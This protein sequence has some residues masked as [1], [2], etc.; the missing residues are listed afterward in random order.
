[1]CQ[2]SDMVVR[3]AA[4][5]AA[6]L[7]LG[8]TVQPVFAHAD[9]EQAK[10]MGGL[11]ALYPSDVDAHA[12]AVPGGTPPEELHLTLVNYGQDVRGQTDAELR[13]RLSDVAAG[14]PQPI[15]AEVY[16][17][18]VFNPNDAQR[19]PSSVYIVGDSTELAWLRQQVFSFSQELFELPAQHEPWVPHVTA[20]YSALETE[21]TYTGM[22][23][24][25]RIGL[26]WA[27]TTTYWPL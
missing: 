20:A 24:F 26:S 12:L 11:V 6:A 25:D 13:R 1:M 23:L 19:D 5:I 14:H 10:T 2:A 7:L 15:K 27:G 17:H 9:V 4:V 22:V 3:L 18:A 21:L 8:P 16:G